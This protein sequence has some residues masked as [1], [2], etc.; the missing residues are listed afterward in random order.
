MEIIILFENYKYK[1]NLEIKYFFKFESSFK[2][3][4]RYKYKFVKIFKKFVSTNK[5]I[6]LFTLIEIINYEN[7]YFYHYIPPKDNTIIFFDLFF[8][9]DY[10]FNA[11]F[12]K[13]KEKILNYLLQRDFPLKKI[14]SNIKNV[15]SLNID[16][17]YK[18]KLYE[19]SFDLVS[20]LN[21]RVDNDYINKKDIFYELNIFIKRNLYNLIIN[22]DKPY[23]FKEISNFI[24]E[25]I[26]I[27][28]KILI[29]KNDILKD[30]NNRIIFFFDEFINALN[31]EF[32]NKYQ[33]YKEF[34]LK[35]ASS[36]YE[37]DKF[38][39]KPKN[40]N[41]IYFAIMLLFIRIKF[42]IFNNI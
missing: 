30:N 8:Q 22:W 34:S 7:S 19:L 36:S 9:F 37:N 10:D 12:D 2:Y 33:L 13:N 16:K 15:N 41:Q 40:I 4:K 20:N 3:Y 29:N 14:F 21:F 31:P 23:D 18:L 35:Y 42:G 32:K 27:F 38:E 5:R 11:F 24:D 25:N 6:A 39:I 26:L 28:F 1:N 17:S